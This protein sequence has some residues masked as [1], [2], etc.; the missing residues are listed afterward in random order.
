MF[1]N[2][3][4]TTRRLTVLCS[5]ALLASACAETG[6]DDGAEST[7]PSDAQIEQSLSSIDDN[8]TID[9]TQDLDEQPGFGDPVFSRAFAED[10]TVETSAGD[11]R[12]DL[13]PDGG[14]TVQPVQV[15]HVLAVWG[16][17][18]PNDNPP[19]AVR[20]NP[21]IE[22][23]QGDAL[24]VRRTVRFDR[25]DR[26]LPQ[27]SRQAVSIVSS[28]QPHI[29][30]V[31]LQVAMTDAD[32]WL[33]FKADNFAIRFQASELADLNEFALLDRAGNGVTFTAI[34]RSDVPDECAAGFVAGRWANTRGEDGGVFGGRWMNEDGTVVGHLAGHYANGDFRGKYIDAD[35]RFR[36][37]LAG[38]YGD[39]VFSGE[40]YDADG[41]QKGNLRGHYTSSQDG[42]AGHGLFRG[43]WSES[44][45]DVPSPEVAPRPG[46]TTEQ[47][48]H[49]T[50]GNGND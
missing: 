6:D 35:G 27:E 15:V 7:A 23:S 20:W 30:G 32:G 28:T 41:N 42:E 5:I 37:F 1:A 48:P 47:E 4:R 12:D 31:V 40:W 26:V 22:V 29:D 13:A 45:D 19:E 3:T 24:R 16:R 21:T 25:Y 49:S 11:V 8:M 46:G 2:S 33:G 44:C 38:V 18:R 17:I 9:G 36:G 39:G 43:A 10:A 14:P 50:S 34:D